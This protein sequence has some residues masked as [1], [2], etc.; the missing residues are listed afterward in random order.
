M[1]KGVWVFLVAWIIVLATAAGQGQS[2]SPTRSSSP[3]PSL[4]A[5][6]TASPHGALIN[7]YCVTCH[8]ERAKT[9]GLALDALSLSNI[10]T[11]AQ[12]WEKVIRRVRGGQMPPAGMPRPPQAALDA[13]VTHLESS[14]DNAAFASPS[15]GSTRPA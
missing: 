14:I 15:E 3:A 1:T 7:Q 5:S 2:P 8:N 13:L 6:A 10:P 11:G 12:T 4:S 9:G